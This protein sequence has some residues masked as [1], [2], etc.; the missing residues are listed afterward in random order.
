M[1]D[2]LKLAAATAMMEDICSTGLCANAKGDHRSAAFAMIAAAF[3][4][5]HAKEDCAVLTLDLVRKM[6]STI[7]KEVEENT[8]MLLAKAAEFAGKNL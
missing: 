7:D 3:I 2:R 8:T 5:A 1:D 6:R 4:A